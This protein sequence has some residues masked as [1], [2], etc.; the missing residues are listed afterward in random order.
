MDDHPY[1]FIIRLLLSAYSAG[2]E[3]NKKEYEQ[4]DKEEAAW[5]EQGKQAN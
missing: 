2:A 1:I 3:E 5:N 4:E